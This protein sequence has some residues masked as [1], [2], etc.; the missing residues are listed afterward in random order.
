M[1]AAN[2]RKAHES[3]KPHLKYLENKG[4]VDFGVQIE[5][6][7]CKG[8]C[9]S[10]PD[11]QHLAWARRLRD[12]LDWLQSGFIAVQSSCL[13]AVTVESWLH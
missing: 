11:S 13:D 5:P 1:F 8:V 3:S 6:S 10:R 7:Q 4:K 12:I 9:L 2:L